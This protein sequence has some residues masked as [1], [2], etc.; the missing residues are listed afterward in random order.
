MSDITELERRISAALDRIGESVSALDNTQAAPADDSDALDALRSAL[1]EEQTANAQLEERVKAIRVKQESLAASLEQEIV[2][3]RQ[4]VSDR[5]ADMQKLE[6]VN[7][8]LRSNNKALR[9]ANETG[10]GEPH[11][12]NKSMMAELESLRASRNG[13]RAELDAILGELKPIV[14][15]RTDA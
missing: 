14:E 3:L 12:I 9:E 15:G 4:Q 1:E 7:T 5:A 13:D 6:H 2:Q 11:L 10:V 8:Q